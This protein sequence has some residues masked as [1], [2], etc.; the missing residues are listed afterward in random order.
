MA[1]EIKLENFSGPFD[2]LCCLIESAEL[3]ICAISL[4]QVVD[5]YVSHVTSAGKHTNLDTMGEFLILAARLLLLKTRV[6]LPQDTTALLKQDE[7]AQENAD[8]LVQHL[9]LYRQY[10][11]LSYTL[12]QMMDKE[13]AFCSLNPIKCE[14]AQPLFAVELPSPDLDSI[15]SAWI[16]L[17]PLFAQWRP[18]AIRSNRPT[19]KDEIASLKIFIRRRHVFSLTQYLGSKPSRFRVATAFLAMLELW[20]QDKIKVRQAAT[21]ADIFLM[22][23]EGHVCRSNH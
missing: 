7:S 23:K 1:H 10:R 21:F 3:D 14:G 13:A 4:A 12:G 5:Q 11:D 19:V 9:K 2:L 22:G 18:V 20:R 6:L 8:Q 16:R 15:V 17:K